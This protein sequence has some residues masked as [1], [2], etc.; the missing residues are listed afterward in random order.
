MSDYRDVAGGKIT[1]LAN[2]NLAVFASGV[3]SETHN[4][5]DLQNLNARGVHVVVDVTAET[6]GGSTHTI[7]VKIQGKDAASGKYYDLLESASI[8][9]TGT[10]ALKVYPGIA[11]ASNVAAS[12]VLPREWRVRIEHTADG[13][14]DMTY[15]VGANL[16]L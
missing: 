9:D 5:Q 6:A 11:A 14:S 2:V 1:G 3:R 4:S 10:T 16:V 8:T 12:D 7:V 15:S 13:A